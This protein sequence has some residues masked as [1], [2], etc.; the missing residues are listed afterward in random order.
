MQ[1]RWGDDVDCTKDAKSS[2]RDFK[3][4]FVEGWRQH[5]FFQLDKRE[6]YKQTY[7][8]FL[9]LLS[10]LLSLLP[11]SNIYFRTSLPTSP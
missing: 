10:C 2:E 6:A 9:V 7:E 8:I 3:D 1:I 5:P 11:P 4:L